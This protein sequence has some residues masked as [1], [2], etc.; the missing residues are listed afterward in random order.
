METTG[1]TPTPQQ[2][3]QT[4][5]N[6]KDLFELV[7]GIAVV[8]IILACILVLLQHL[9]ADDR[10]QRNKEQI[11]KA[12]YDSVQHVYN[13]SVNMYKDSLTLLRRRD[14]VLVRT[15]QRQDAS[16]IQIDNKYEKVSNDVTALPVNGRVSFL[17]KWLSENDS[18][19]QR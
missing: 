4:K 1:M 19:S 10:L 13:D 17:A 5:K 9:N 6:S 3:E 12:K 7:I 14:T 8:V 18:A 16:L 2:P 11:N 15:L